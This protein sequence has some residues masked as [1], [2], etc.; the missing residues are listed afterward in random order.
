MLLNK[1]KKERNTGIYNYLNSSY[2]KFDLDTYYSSYSNK[3]P[4]KLGSSLSVPD[5][6]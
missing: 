1:R 4:A 6:S 3:F 5:S 2:L